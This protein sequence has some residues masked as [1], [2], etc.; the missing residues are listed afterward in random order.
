MAGLLAGRWLQD[1]V[2]AGRA[3]SR[4]IT[5]AGSGS[6]ATGKPAC[7]AWTWA[8]TT[9]TGYGLPNFYVIA[10]YNHSTHYAMA[11]WELGKEVDRV[12]HRSVVR[13]D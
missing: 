13:Q 9:S 5:P 6:A 2:P 8:G 10:R 1:A 12:R 11:V 7:C 4:R 3:P